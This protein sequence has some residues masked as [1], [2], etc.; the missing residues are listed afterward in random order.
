[1][2]E[3][4]TS[5]AA[6][7]ALAV[8]VST[9]EYGR[10]L[11]PLPTGRAA[12]AVAKSS[13]SRRFVALTR[14]RL[15]TWLAQPLDGLDVRVVLI[16]GLHFRDHVIFLAL[17]IAADGHKHVLALGKAPPRMRRSARVC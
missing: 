11:D 3:S 10:V 16:D 17:G 12:R 7:E 2:K 1:M 6:W 4:R 9:R 14:A 5:V 15:T 8:G 13:V